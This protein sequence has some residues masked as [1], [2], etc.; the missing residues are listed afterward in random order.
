MPLS[1]PRYLRLSK[2]LPHRKH[3]QIRA[4]VAVVNNLVRIELDALPQRHDGGR[5]FEAVGGLSFFFLEFK[6]YGWVGSRGRVK[7]LGTME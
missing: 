6:V 7:K 5:G 2:P 1:M 3:E 4:L